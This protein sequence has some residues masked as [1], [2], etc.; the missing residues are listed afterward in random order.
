MGYPPRPFVNC[1][2]CNARLS[3]GMGRLIELRRPR[4]ALLPCPD[5]GNQDVYDATMIRDALLVPA[6]E[7]KA[8]QTSPALPAEAEAAGGL[9]RF[10]A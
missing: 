8:R 10:S 1:H 7:P 3:L 5:C 9:H 4:G 2:F 6:A